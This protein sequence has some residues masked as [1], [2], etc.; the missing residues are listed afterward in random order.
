MIPCH[1]CGADAS[2]GWIHGFVPSPDSLKMGLCREHDTPDNRKLV[3]AAWRALMQ[4]EIQAMTDVSGYKAGGSG[5]LRLDIA[6]IGGGQVTQECLDCT[7]TPQGTLQVL[8]PDGTLRF[9]PLPQ[10]R[11][12]DLRPALTPA[13]EKA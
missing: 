11:R 6:F 8:L 5:R 2:T 3:K 10:I 4:R 1:A 7:A 12:Y 13:A 9:Y